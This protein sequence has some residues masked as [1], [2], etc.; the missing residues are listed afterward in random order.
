LTGEHDH[1]QVQSIAFGFDKLNPGLK[2][3]IIVQHKNLWKITV[4]PKIFHFETLFLCP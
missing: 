1:G 3:S 4:F 2:S